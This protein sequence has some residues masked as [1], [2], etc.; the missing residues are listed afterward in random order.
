MR[1][2]SWF[3]PT[4]WGIVLIWYFSNI[5]ARPTPALL[6]AL[7]RPCTSAQDD[8][9]G[10]HPN[11]YI[12]LGRRRHHAQQGATQRVRLQA[13]IS[14]PSQDNAKSPS[15]LPLKWE[16]CAKCPVWL[17]MPTAR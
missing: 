4:T 12:E 16:S 5:G 7:R 3:N 1:L 15:L 2:P 17:V 14:P 8:P 10:V 11:T 13:R 9:Y 6:A